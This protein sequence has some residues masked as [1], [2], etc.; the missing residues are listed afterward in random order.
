MKYL[1]SILHKEWKTS[2]ALIDSRALWRSQAEERIE[3]FKQDKDCLTN[4]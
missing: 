1:A 3:R 4:Q 2:W